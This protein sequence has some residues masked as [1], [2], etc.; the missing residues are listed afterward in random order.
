MQLKQ[1]EVNAM[2]AKEAEIEDRKDK[3]TKLQ[4][5]QQ[6]KMID[7]R[8]NNTLPINFDQEQFGM[9]LETFQPK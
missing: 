7:Q 6:S 8:K 4:A 5:T 9:E 1:I 2:S 3:R